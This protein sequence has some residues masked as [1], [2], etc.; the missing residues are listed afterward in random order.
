MLIN[1][2]YVSVMNK[3]NFNIACYRTQHVNV[4][5]HPLI[6]DS[7]T[8]SIFNGRGNWTAREQLRLLDAIEQF[9]F[10]NWEDISKHIETRTP[11]GNLTSIFYKC[12]KIQSQFFSIYSYLLSSTFYITY[13]QLQRKQSGNVSASELKLE[14]LHDCYSILLLFKSFYPLNVGYPG[15]LVT[16]TG[17]CV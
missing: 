11:E 3:D 15:L 10:G 4:L 6:Q 14:A 12:H 9:G 8:I 2:W 1:L 17:K 7:G 13:I 16:K 5:L